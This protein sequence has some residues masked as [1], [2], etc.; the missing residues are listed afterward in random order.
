MAEPPPPYPGQGAPV[1]CPNGCETDP[2]TLDQLEKHLQDCPRQVVD[3]EFAIA[4]CTEVVTRSELASHMAENAQQHLVNATLYNLRMTRELKQKMEERDLQ[5]ADL[6][7]Q[8]K[9]LT[10]HSVNGFVGY[11]LVLNDFE[12]LRTLGTWRSNIFKDQLEGLQ[13][14]LEISLGPKP[15]KPTHLL[16]WLVL[17]AHRY[18][19]DLSLSARCRLVLKMLNQLGDSNHY[20][21]TTDMQF[22]SWETKDNLS[23]NK[24]GNGTEEFFPL[25]ELATRDA[26]Y[27]KQ[28]QLRFK[29]YLKTD[30]F[31]Q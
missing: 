22:Q 9:K 19:K 6:Q 12:S 27:L 17:K 8:L 26:Q 25:N 30:Y 1:S 14:Y 10:L 3:C 20:V 28:N 29:L 18:G 21:V 15:R 4:G 7:K 23:K 2:L 5:I 16:V 31:S 11:D 24:V 13:F